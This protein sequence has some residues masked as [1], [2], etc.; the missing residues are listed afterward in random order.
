MAEPTAESTENATQGK[1]SGDSNKKEV[2]ILSNKDIAEMK[3]RQQASIQEK[4]DRVAMQRTAALDPIAYE[5]LKVVA[6]DYMDSDAL[7]SSFKNV[8]QV[9]RVLQAAKSL[10]VTFEDAMSG[11]Y[12]VNGQLNIYGK[13]TPTVLKNAGYSWDFYDED[14]EFTTCTVKIWKGG[15][16][17]DPEKEAMQPDPETTTEFYKDTFTLANAKASGYGNGVGFKDG[18]NR[19]RKLRYEALS[20]LIHTRLPHVLNGVAGIAE[21]SER[22]QEEFDQSNQAQYKKV[23]K[24]SIQD[25]MERADVIDVDDDDANFKPRPVQ[26]VQEQG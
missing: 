26:P 18:K 22:Y 10:G 25:R 2:K 6:Q 14:D 4:Q 1:K 11:M 17:F 13:L 5:Q 19:Q 20:L 23:D 3:K 21:V 12:Y 9:L 8:N 24:Q 7:P 15:S 16:K